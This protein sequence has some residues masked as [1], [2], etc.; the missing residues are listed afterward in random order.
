MD[1]RIRP[2][3]LHTTAVHAGEAPDPATGALAT[4]IHLSTAFHLGTAERG[5]AVFSGREEAYVYSR[6]ANPTVSAFERKAAALEGAEAA[7]ATASGMAAI[8]SAIFTSVQS[9]DHIVS[10][11]AIYPSTYHL[12]ATQL[13]SMGVRTTFVDATDPGNVARAIGPST[14]LVYLETPGN[15]TLALCDL[16]AIG[17]I[18]RS[19][20]L[21]TICDNTFASPVNQRPLEL[22]IDTVVHSAT[23]Y[24]C[25]HGDAV[26][27]LVL[28]RAAFIDRCLK[29]PLRYYGGIMAPFSAY[30]M[31]RGAATMP[32]RV[33]RQNSSALRIAE[34]LERHRAVAR[35]L[36]PGLPSHPQ[37]ALAKRQMPGGFGGIVCFDLAGGVEAGARLMNAVRVC[38]LATSLGDARTLISHPA[39]TTHSVVP[40]EARLAQGVTDGLVRLSVGIEDVEDLVADLDAGLG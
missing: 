28:G 31:L 2:A 29:E 5:A 9:G 15:P 26:G 7:I 35:V 12:M 16:E 40:P 36:Y 13:A 34:W 22:G 32:L 19:A 17:R 4:P 10:A 3:G 1:A 39:S 25:G 30:L 27:G 6:W 24:F 14:K 37:H 38:S 23:K 20:G 33:M 21:A 11:T 8:A 18:A